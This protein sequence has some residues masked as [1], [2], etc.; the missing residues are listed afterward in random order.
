M[1]VCFIERVY[2]DHPTGTLTF[3]YQ[4]RWQKTARNKETGEIL[5]ERSPVTVQPGAPIS[6]YENFLVPWENGTDD[7]LLVTTVVK[8]RDAAPVTTKLKFRILYLTDSWDYLQM[9]DETGKVVA[10]IEVGTVGNTQGVN[11]SGWTLSLNAR[12]KVEFKRDWRHG[13][14]HKSAIQLAIGIVGGAVA[15]VGV[16]AAFVLGIGV[17][18]STA[19]ST[20]AVVAGTLAVGTGAIVGV[21]GVGTAAAEGLWSLFMPD[22]PPGIEQ[23]L[24]DTTRRPQDIAA[25]KPATASSAYSPEYGARKAN[26]GLSPGQGGWAS[27]AGDHRG[28]WQV[29]LGEPVSLDR[30]QL[31]TRQDLDQP[32]TRRNFEIRVSNHPD[33]SHGHTVLLSQGDLETPFRGALD[34]TVFDPSP[35]RY[36]AVVKTDDAHFFIAK[37]RAFARPP[38]LAARKPAAASSTWS[39][40]HAADKANDGGAIA[41]GGW[42]PATGN[43][44]SFWQVDLGEAR[45]L[46]RIELVTRQDL[47]QPETRQNFEIWASNN[48]DM[49]GGHVVLARRG[50]RPMA[51]REIF[52]AEIEDPTPYRY[53]RAVKTVPE[54]FFIAKL[55][56]YGA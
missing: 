19:G 51:F 37:L 4:D 46:S 53:L 20:T 43:E 48:A 28:A 10:A 16:G 49:S 25:G 13:M 44:R 3:Q 54:Y 15:L 32:E 33:M 47:D 31:V 27:A 35:Y 21:V 41:T 45:R 55:C 42:S 30:I 34:V 40:E 6:N 23:P 2:N 36:I 29:D 11:W 18:I 50:P 1:A 22:P 26:D 5:T 38:D 39:A 24:L 17:I 7:H 14:A 9:V 52:S 56:V 8:H 12:G